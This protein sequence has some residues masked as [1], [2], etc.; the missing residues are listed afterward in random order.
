MDRLEVILTDYL[1][2]LLQADRLLQLA[3]LAM[4]VVVLLLVHA[5]QVWQY[6][7]FYF[8][9][10]RVW[11]AERLGRH[12]RRWAVVGS[13]AA[14][15]IGLGYI[16]HGIAPGGP[17]END[18]LQEQE[19]VEL[20]QRLIIPQLGLDTAIVEVEYAGWQWDLSRLHDQVGHL[21]GTS[22]PGQPGNMVLAGHVTLYEGGW[23]PFA[24]LAS[25]QPGDKLFIA[26]G[27][28]VL[29]YQVTELRLVMPTDVSVVFPTSDMRLT[30]ITCA[31]WQE[32]DAAYL[33]RLVV[34]ARR[35]A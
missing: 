3:G 33:R 6:R 29:T 8:E 31:D 10:C 32:V 1:F 5:S 11:R 19:I 14:V 16:R 35:I 23:G 22:P 12:L 30:L 18:S 34:I 2:A 7:A 4:G 21:E 25:L 17:A 15:G 20:P 26:E 24:E 9:D 28:Y 13:M 27:S